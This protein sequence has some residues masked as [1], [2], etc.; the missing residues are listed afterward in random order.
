LLQ[1]GLP[2]E[3]ARHDSLATFLCDRSKFTRWN[4][5]KYAIES[6]KKLIS[7]PQQEKK[8][9]RKR[10]DQVQRPLASHIRVTIPASIAQLVKYYNTCQD[11]F[12]TQ[13][14]EVI[15]NL[16]PAILYAKHCITKII[17][18]FSHF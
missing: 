9:E 6:S 11:P 17:S 13:E 16:G 18:H 2:N 12:Q 7:D 1:K 8:V 15:Q 10:E 5:N 14:C 4:A 3:N